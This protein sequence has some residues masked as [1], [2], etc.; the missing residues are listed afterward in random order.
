MRLTSRQQH[1]E[2]GRSGAS[3]WAIVG[4]FAGTLVGLFFGLPG[5]LLGPFVGAVAGEYLSRGSLH[6]ATLAGFGTWMG[7]VAG[8]AVKLALV[9]TM[10]G[11]GVARFLVS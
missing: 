1:W 3:R 8:A 11:I 2:P 6:E 5:L 10:V 9:C 4:A 7:I